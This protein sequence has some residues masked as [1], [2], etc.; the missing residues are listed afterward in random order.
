MQCVLILFIITAPIIIIKRSA[1]RRFVARLPV[2][3]D[4]FR[5]KTAN[6]QAKIYGSNA[7]A[8]LKQK[9]QVTNIAYPPNKIAMVAIKDTRQL[10]IYSRDDTN[11]YHYI[12][13]Y[14]ILGASGNLGPKLRLGDRQ[15]PEGLYQLSLEPN[16]PYHLALR[17]NYPNEFDLKHASEEN[18]NPGSD[19]LIHGTRGSVGCIAMGDEVSE[20]Y[21]LWFMIVLTK[22]LS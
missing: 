19:I 5:L 14:P 8:R 21:L 1:F 9:F 2:I 13:S 10:Q 3:G 6:E 7:R 4:R 17:L 16:T 12:C 15:V 11:R 18:R 20:V 22:N